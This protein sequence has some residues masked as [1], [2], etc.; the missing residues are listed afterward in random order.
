MLT[1]KFK[2]ETQSI[3]G[4]CACVE[5]PFGSSSFTKQFECSSTEVGVA[6]RAFVVNILAGV[7]AE[8][9]KA[10]EASTS[11][12]ADNQHEDVGVASS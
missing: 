5:P 9:D 10:A 8:W 7:H 4:T 2:E 11:E 12:K 3:S 1:F 6:D